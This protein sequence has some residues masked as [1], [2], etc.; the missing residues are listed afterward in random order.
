MA[1]GGSLL[2][3]TFSFALAGV[4]SYPRQAPQSSFF[5]L[6]SRSPLFFPSLLSLLFYSPYFK[7]VLLSRC[8]HFVSRRNDAAAQHTLYRMN[9]L[10]QRMF[11]IN[12][13]IFYWT[14]YCEATS[15]TLVIFTSGLQSLKSF[16]HSFQSR[17]MKFII[18]MSHYFSMFHLS[19]SVL[20]EVWGYKV[21]R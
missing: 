4:F 17:G 20:N 18:L 15:L 10:G 6:S 19:A 9:S 1:A 2:N 21:S 5:L 14:A 11:P 7:C 3:P 8:L 16:F 13:Y 12:I